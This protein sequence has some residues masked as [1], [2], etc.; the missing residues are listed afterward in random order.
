MRVE[1]MP[2]HRSLLQTFTS[3]P[4]LQPHDGVDLLLAQGVEHDELVHTVDKLG[5]EVGAYLQR[6][7][8]R[9]LSQ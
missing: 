1:I 7:S 3:A 8:I 5:A 6:M 9:V 2:R 4:H